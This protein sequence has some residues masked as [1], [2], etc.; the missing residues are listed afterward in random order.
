MYSQRRWH[1]SRYADSSTAYAL[2]AG[3][4]ITTPQLNPP[5]AHVS[6]YLSCRPIVI[7]ADG[8]VKLVVSPDNID[9]RLP[10]QLR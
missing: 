9:D 3:G 10:S 2:S 5:I 1:H 7:D 4:P 6:P 8:E